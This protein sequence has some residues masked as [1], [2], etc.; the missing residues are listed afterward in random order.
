MLSVAG[1]RNIIPR[2]IVGRMRAYARASSSV[3]SSSGV[4]EHRDVFIF[5]SS[6]P[7]KQWATILSTPPAYNEN[8]SNQNLKHPQSGHVIGKYSLYQFENSSFHFNNVGEYF[9]NMTAAHSFS[10][11]AIC[12]VDSRLEA[13]ELEGQEAR[14]SVLIW[15]DSLFLHN[16]TVDD[17]PVVTKLVG[18]QSKKLSVEEAEKMF[19]DAGH[20]EGSGVEVM[21][22]KDVMVMVACGNEEFHGSANKLQ[23]LKAI[24]DRLI[25]AEGLPDTCTKFFMTADVRGHRNASK[26]MIF[27]GGSADGD[28]AAAEDCFENLEDAQAGRTLSS[29]LK[30]LK[31]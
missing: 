17:I 26:V 11:T 4:V 9:L 8:N 30:A 20:D 25:E 24:S 2:K 19:S 16:V 18:K 14:H 21:E 22:A 7:L 10:P 1:A 3:A 29:H 28:N 15:P 31:E 6:W 5:D 13:A 12:H 23:Q 27:S